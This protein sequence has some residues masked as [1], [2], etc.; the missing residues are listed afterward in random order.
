LWFCFFLN[1]L[2]HIPFMNLP[3]QSI[4][5]WRQCSTLAVARNFYEEDMNIL[6]PRLDDRLDR[7]GVTGMQFPSYEYLVALGYELF[8]EHNWVY[9]SVSFLIYCMG[10]WGIYELFF[11]LFQTTWAAGLAAWS[12]SW[13]PELFYFGISALPDVTALAASLWGL[14]LFIRWFKSGGAIPYGLSL[15]L[16]TLAGLT[17]IQYLVI[18]FPIAILILMEKKKHSL[19]RI[20]GM[21]FFA[22][23]SVGLTLGWYFHAVQLIHTSGLNDYDIG[24]TPAPGWLWALKVIW[25]N[26]HIEIPEL[27]LNYATFIFL[28]VGI[29]TCF[30]QKKI[31]SDWFGPLAVWGG[32]VLAYYFIELGKMDVHSYYLLPFLPLLLVFVIL[33][34][35]VLK[36]SKYAWVFIFLLVAQ[37]IVAFFRI[38]PPRFW[39]KDK[40]VPQELYF[41]ASRERLEKAAPNDALCVV[42][43]DNSRAVYFYFLHK[44]GFAFSELEDLAALSDGKPQL[45]RDIQRGARYLY[46]D[47][48]KISQSKVLKPLLESEILK[49]GSFQVFKLALPP[50]TKGI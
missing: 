44:K 17:K 27:I 29:F 36:D 7:D 20:L 46:T 22:L 18:G 26:A 15:I 24:F 14:A 39:A 5:V 50:G 48:P 4:H 12:F 8:G 35:L 28:L 21:A 33:G 25:H 23:T 40:A 19:S 34:G 49:E 32:A 2:L 47:D 11:I 38:V 31:K 37:P 30:K 43:G 41:E 10:A 45:E 1:L 13:S 9:R 42:G 6:K 3:P 16:T